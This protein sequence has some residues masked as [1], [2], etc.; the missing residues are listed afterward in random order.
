MD[1]GIKIY[2]ANCDSIFSVVRHPTTIEPHNES[3]EVGVGYHGRFGAG[4]EGVWFCPFC[5]KDERYAP[6]K[7]IEEEDGDEV[8]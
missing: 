4:E 3:E 5:G 7:E 1:V 2:C 8:K 6:L